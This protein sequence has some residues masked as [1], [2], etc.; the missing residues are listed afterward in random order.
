MRELEQLQATGKVGVKSEPTE[1]LSTKESIP[2]SIETISDS[3][4]TQSSPHC[5]QP[6]LDSDSDQN[7]NQ[8]Q[9]QSSDIEFC[10][11]QRNIDNQENEPIHDTLPSFTVNT[12]LFLRFIEIGKTAFLT[13]ERTDP[14]QNALSCKLLYIATS[15]TKQGNQLNRVSCL[16]L[17]RGTVVTSLELKESDPLSAI[18]CIPANSA[19]LLTCGKVCHYYDS[20]S[21]TIFRSIFCQDP[22]L[23][24]SSSEHPYLM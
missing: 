22:I 1:S 8:N 9:N 16:D 11:E 3:T 24:T 18:T 21:N 4:S 7:Q 5:S 12:P 2:F 23:R 20:R 13:P 15:S 17:E 6:D 14:F 10:Q 19:I